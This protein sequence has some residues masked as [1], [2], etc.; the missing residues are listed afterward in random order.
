MKCLAL[1]GKRFVRCGNAATWYGIL[2]GRCHRQV[3]VV[4][5]A[6]LA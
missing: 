5:R 3:A 1:I 6:R 4:I 2:C